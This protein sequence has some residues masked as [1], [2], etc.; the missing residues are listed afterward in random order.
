MSN[1]TQIYKCLNDYIESEQTNG[2]LLITGQWG[3]GKTFY[4]K[5]YINDNKSNFYF[6]MISLFGLS[7]TEEIKK[8]INRELSRVI[9]KIDENS[10]FHKAFSGIKKVTDNYKEDSEAIHL[11]DTI[12][13]SNIYDYIGLSEKIK[14]K[15]LVLVFDDFERCKVDI[16][17]I[18]GL[19]NFYCETM[20]I[21]VIIIADEKHISDNINE[22][23]E[24]NKN[25]SYH[26]FKE[27]VIY[28]TFTLLPDY[29]E[30]ISL[31]IKSYKESGSNYQN[32]LEE[33]VGVL[34]NALEE[35]TYNNFRSIKSVVIDFEKIYL[36]YVNLCNFN[37]SHVFKSYELQAIRLSLYQYCAFTLEYRAGNAVYHDIFE[38]DNFT[39]DGEKIN[40]E[41]DLYPYME[42]YNHEIY[43]S[44]NEA[45]SILR[46]VENG[47][48]DEEAVK[49]SIQNIIN[50]YKPLDL[51]P[52]ELFLSHKTYKLEW[53][54][55][56]KGYVD[57]LERSYS[58]ELSSDELLTF[59]IKI[60]RIHRDEIELPELP[61][62][63]KMDKAYRIENRFD[64]PDSP[65]GPAQGIVEDN[66]SELAKKIRDFLNR[67]TLIK[68]ENDA[69]SILK[70][71]F[72][73]PENKSS[74]DIYSI[75]KVIPTQE[76]IDLFLYKIINTRNE[77]REEIGNI[78][79]N[80]C[81]AQC[82]KVQLDEIIEELQTFLNSIEKDQIA[83]LI[84]KG[85]I[86]SLNTDS[87][88]RDM[89]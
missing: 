54:M 73:C 29:K 27:K 71:Y 30:V 60:A 88:Q 14:D 10:I 17:D 64:E 45:E 65:F 4:M 8:C 6:S 82:S 21:K 48:W 2:A 24:D 84:I 22:D 81:A 15:K 31:I 76:L 20:N 39:E 19:I 77:Y 33:N 66:A 50:R 44:I 83:K 78:F 68:R 58:G 70:E 46:F 35:S 12:L 42:K 67:K 25:D 59:L 53:D 9:A 23:K 87:V 3:S 11:V 13:N 51:K 80:H 89:I 16:I 43:D 85:F 38:S 69:I 49:A 86:I 79:L 56:E 62:Y 75:G 61:D 1:L 41:T 55:F 36:L 52:Y 34:V 47:L 7:S 28:K 26:E 57:A 63:A 32:F 18:L 72:T 5:H 74:S 37:N 40:T